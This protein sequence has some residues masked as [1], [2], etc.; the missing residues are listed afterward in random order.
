[1]STTIQP[2]S[3]PLIVHVLDS[4]GVG[5][6]EMLVVNTVKE[7][8]M[9]RH[10][11]VYLCMPD[12]LKSS[13]PPDTQ[14][15]FLDHKRG[16]GAL[17]TILKL[18]RLIRRERPALVH[19]HLLWPTI[20]TRLACPADVKMAFT[21][22]TPLSVDAY[23]HNPPVR[24]LDKITYTK[25]QVMI[26]V[27]KS[28]WEDYKEH[29][30][31]KGKNVV[32]YNFVDE[33]FFSNP[34]KPLEP[35]LQERPLKLVAVGNLRAVKNHRFL[36]E[37][38][39]QIKSDSATL[40]IY[41]EGDL[42]P[43]LQ[44]YIDEH[45]LPVRLCGRVQHIEKLL[46]QY[47]A[48]VMSSTLEGH[49]IAVA[50]AMASGIPMLLSDIPTLREGSFGLAALYS[51]DRPENFVQALTDFREHYYSQ[52]I[53]QAGEAHKVAAEHYSREAYVGKIAALYKEIIETL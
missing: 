10:L 1:M 25:R 51:L 34:W 9:Y 17:N 26:A 29:V 36:L 11:V 43:S 47:D 48:F 6:T 33:R 15:I 12:Q 45:Q 2:A 19:A 46:P 22:H 14:V 35:S 31:L 18:R 52:I 13:L 49:S 41:G 39:R 24:L 28:V 5:G 16:I 32:L 20:Y 3:G 21:V 30:G 50:E 44:Q 27:S 42:R 38:F 8:S 4:L 40:D 53:S 7:L 23:Q 37:A